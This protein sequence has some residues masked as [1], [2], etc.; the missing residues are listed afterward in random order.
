MDGQTKWSNE[1]VKRNGQTK[2]SNNGQTMG[3]PWPTMSNRDQIM[4]K[5]WSNGAMSGRHAPGV[6]IPHARAAL[7]AEEMRRQLE[8]ARLEADRARA[9]KDREVQHPPH[10]H[11]DLRLY[12]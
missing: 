4:V 1:M 2:W 6:R 5:Y 10:P 7:Q 8:A 9:E 11:L 12:Q 3:E